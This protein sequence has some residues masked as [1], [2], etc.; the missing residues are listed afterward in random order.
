MERKIFGIVTMVTMVAVLSTVGCAWGGGLDEGTDGV[1]AVLAFV[2]SDGDGVAGAASAKEACDILAEEYQYQCRQLFDGDEVG[3]TS[4]SLRVGDCDDND[5]ATYPGA[6]EICDGRD[7][8][9]DGEIDEGLPEGCCSVDIDC[10]DGDLCTGTETCVSNACV[11]GTSLSCD[12]E[13]LCTTDSCDPVAGCVNEIVICDDNDEYTIDS[14]E[15]TSGCVYTSIECLIDIECDDDDVCT[16]DS[17]QTGVCV[18]TNNI[19]VCEDGNVCTENDQCKA[20]AC[21]SGPVVDCNDGNACTSDTCDSIEGCMNVAVS[22]DDSNYYTADSCDPL[23][24]CINTPLECLIDADCDDVNL[25]TG[26]ETCVFNACVSGTLLDCDDTDLCTTDSCDPVVGC[27]NEIVICDDINA[28]TIDSCDPATGCVYE[29]VDCN[30]DDVLTIDSCDQEFG[31]VHDALECDDSDICTDDSV[32]MGTG[33]CLFTSINCD[34]DDACTTDS[35]DPAT[36]CMNTVMTNCCLDGDDS[37]CAS[38]VPTGYS[39]QDEGFWHLGAY[40]YGC[41]PTEDVTDICAICEDVDVDGVCVLHEVNCGDGIDGDW[42]GMVDCEDS[43]C[44]MSPVCEVD[45]CDGITCTDGEVCQAGVCV[46]EDTQAVWCWDMTRSDEVY[47]TCHLQSDNQYTYWSP[48]EWLWSDYQSEAPQC[49]SAA[50]VPVYLPE[51]ECCVGPVELSIGWQCYGN[52]FD[53]YFE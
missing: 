3:S 21:A 17:C 48:R 23:V 2:D 45:L 43:D 9:C 52:T 27:V 1:L 13:D 24:G 41:I 20:G 22:C 5:P 38:W 6:E 15:P 51:A 50:D 11:E 7:N 8:D 34:D 14:C 12:D 31:C 42:D 47:P 35:C 40:T 39:E 26:V 30:D 10:D 46:L 32:D 28:C 49:G 37:M 36:G 29:T 25:C 19:V 18:Y 4:S 53:P 16:T 33:E 44:A